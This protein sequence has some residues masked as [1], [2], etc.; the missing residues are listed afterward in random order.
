MRL[1][2]TYDEVKKAI[3]DEGLVNIVGAQADSLAKAVDIDKETIIRSNRDEI[4]P[5][6]EEEIAV[7]YYFHP[8]GIEIRLRTDTQLHQAMDKWDES[9]KLLEPSESK[10]ETA[11]AS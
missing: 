9:M 10:T 11:T 8:A 2:K 6:I 7:R 3:E 4:I 1:S 5:F